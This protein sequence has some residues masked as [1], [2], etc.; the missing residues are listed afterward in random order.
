MI[1]HQ[2][3]AELVAVN[4]LT[5]RQTTF[6]VAFF[7]Q[8]HAGAAY[9]EA[10]NVKPTA[11]A[12]TVTREA[13]RLLQH[14]KIAPIIAELRQHELQTVTDV[15]GIDR[16]LIL[17]E[18]QKLAMANIE[19]YGYRDEHGEFVV[20]LSGCTREQLAAIQEI[21][22]EEVKTEAGPLRRTR[23]KLHNK[24]HA[25]VDMGKEI[26]MFVDRKAVDVTVVTPEVQERQRIAREKVYEMLKLM[27][28]GHFPG[29]APLVRVID[30]EPQRPAAAKPNGKG[31]GH[32]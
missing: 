11:K 8:R 1:D 13:G 23:I 12:R 21:I 25:L 14:P 20:D 3:L 15:S 17:G 6:I 30:H 4:R 27:E 7:E 29:E 22:T 26:G 2:R 18:L 5:Q 9:R 28:K 19:D 24:R 16:N 31:N 10:Y 32:G